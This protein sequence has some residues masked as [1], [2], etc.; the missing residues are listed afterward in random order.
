V[1]NEVKED[2]SKSFEKSQNRWNLLFVDEN[3]DG[4]FCATKPLFDDSGGRKNFMFDFPKKKYRG[5]F[6]V[7]REEFD[8]LKGILKDDFNAGNWRKDGGIYFDDYALNLMAFCADFRVRNLMKAVEKTDGKWTNVF[9]VL[10]ARNDAIFFLLGRNIG[11]RILPKCQR[12]K[13]TR[14]DLV[15]GRYGVRKK[16]PSGGGRKSGRYPGQDGRDVGVKS[17]ASQQ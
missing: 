12:R 8:K 5:E 17:L 14:K 15:S 3:F 6:G 11:E 2:E 1:E 10:K 7:F 4:N 13:L 9:Q 16:W